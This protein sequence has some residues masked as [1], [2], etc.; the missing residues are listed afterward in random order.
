[1][2]LKLQYAFYLKFWKQMIQ[3]YQKCIC[4]DIFHFVKYG[5]NWHNVFISAIPNLYVKYI[6][7]I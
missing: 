2:D 7:F 3:R 5:S 4:G 1:M 6:S